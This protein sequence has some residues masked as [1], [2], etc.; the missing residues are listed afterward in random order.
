MRDQ[1]FRFLLVI[2]G[3]PIVHLSKPYNTKTMVVE[4]LEKNGFREIDNCVYMKMVETGDQISGF[5][6]EHQ[7]A[8]IINDPSA[9][10]AESVIE[11]YTVNEN[12][13][14]LVGFR[15]A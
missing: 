15:S 4:F 5:K 2:T 8:T 14:N 11:G 7:T 9:P 6:M 13:G 12:D 1:S 3:N 10:S